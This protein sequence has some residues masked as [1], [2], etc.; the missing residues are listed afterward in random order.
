MKQII[1][2]ALVLIIASVSNAATNPFNS[3]N[4]VTAFFNQNLN[5]TLNYSCIT[6]YIPIDWYFP[7]SNS[8]LFYQMV[9]MQG[10]IWPNVPHTTPIL[11][12][13]NGGPG[14]SSQIGSWE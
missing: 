6:G 1:L 10:Q 13:F 9:T 2:I 12:W 14:S 8:S 7:N 11:F 5:T 4:D 3:D